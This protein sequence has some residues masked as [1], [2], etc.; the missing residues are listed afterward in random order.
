MTEQPR[1]PSVP[2]KPSLDGLEDK[3]VRAW[4]DAGVYRF[5]RTRP[6]G[7]VYSIDTPPPTVS[8]SLHVGHVFSYTH[9]DTVAR[10]HRMRGRAVFYP[11]GW[12]DN[13]LPTERRVQNH[14]G[15]RCEPS[16]P[17]DPEFEPPAEPDPKRQVPV[18]R[19]NFIELCERLTE[20]DEKAFEEMW[21]RVGLSVDWTH[22]YSTI[23]EASRTASQRAFLRNLARGEAYVSEAPTLWD[24]TFR[25]A[26]AQAEL[27]DREQPGAFHRIR[28][29][30][31]ERPV[32]VETTRPELLPACVALVAHPDDERYQELFG[33]MVRTP[34]FGVEVPVLG[35]RLAEPDKGSG[36][37]MICTFGDVT[38]VTWWR[39]LNLPTRAVIGW[40]GRLSA[41]PPAGVAAEPY[42]ELAGKTVFSAK[43][44][45]VE[46]L[47]ESGDLDG[48]PRRIS[49]PVKFYE[50]GNKPLEIV[51]TR[52][53][54][55]RN[56]GRDAA[57]RAELLARGA[58]LNWHPPYMRARYENW[59]EG[60]NGDWLIS[61]QRFFGVP[62]PVWYPLDASGEPRYD[63]PIVPAEDAL[64]V[65]PSSDVPPGFAE[66]QRGKPDGFVGDPDVMDTWATS[67]LTPQIAG[68]WERDADLFSRVFPYDLRPQAHD[69]IRTWLFSTV[70]RSHL[71]H[72]SLPWTD[73]ALSGW[74]LDP[75]RKKM[76]KSKGNVVTP[77]G[78]LREYG[79]DAVR[80]WAASG[81]PGTDTAFDTG[82]IK[83][84]RRLAIKILNA[85]K[86]V[87]GLGEVERGAAVT[88]PL[89]RAM[90]ASLSGV[91]ADATEAFE[92]YDYARALERT[93]RF[94]WEFCDDYLELVK[95]RA[96][97]EGPEAQSARAALRSAL[98][99]LLRLFAPV[100]PFVTEE[101]WSWWRKGSVHAASW[102]LAAEL[103]ADGDPAV[104][105]ATAEALRQVRKAKSEAKASMR[106]D[107]SRAVVRGAEAGRVSRSDLAAAGRIAELTL[108]S[109]PA[110]LTVDVTLA[111]AD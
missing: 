84:G 59:V 46:M 25:T 18:S 28:F 20:V 3:W 88:E 102:P 100:L 86:F 56:G 23:G 89:D 15:V 9:T 73:T 101:V 47:R 6:R 22:L 26:V 81:R 62:I 87:L 10:F 57:T 4:E 68:G 80:Y 24:V 90:L 43:E 63:A 41:E 76:S 83:V 33:T 31:D 39:E 92:G 1:T 21:R 61:R 50:K 5:D 97:G 67:S 99:V 72:G 7:E 91:V 96:Y 49:R 108:E 36:I 32:Y 71:E 58:E 77:I 79:S 98:S 44:R 105:A 93:E 53:W 34:L 74:I 85:S 110:D 107:V 19:R 48:E 60:L 94:F 30:G 111:P 2:P 16:L 54:Y 52:Q 65:D 35:H 40:D 95:A 70:V 82:Q 8:G 78:L 109:A 37:A 38:D 13:G 17:Y 75:D 11:M 29:H 42:A 106:A 103:P 55:I 69:I 51:T 66:D 64:P 27:E 45:V 12:D 14:F 104:L